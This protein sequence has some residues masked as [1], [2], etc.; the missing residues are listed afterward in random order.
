MTVADTESRVPAL[1]TPH[2][3]PPCIYLTQPLPRPVRQGG[4]PIRGE[5]QPR[6]DLG[7]R[8]TLDLG[9]PQHRAASTGDKFGGNRSS[10]NFRAIR[11]YLE[12]AK[13]RQEALRETA[14]GSTKS[15]A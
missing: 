10:L 7:G 1:V 11:S 6:R 8:L 2:W 13:V 9:V 5:A 12:E 4:Y 15:V 14:R 3:T